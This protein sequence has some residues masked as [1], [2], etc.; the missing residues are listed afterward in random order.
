MTDHS[1]QALLPSPSRSLGCN[2]VQGATIFDSISLNYKRFTQEFS[3]Y[4]CNISL[5]SSFKVG[6]GAF[7][8]VTLVSSLKVWVHLQEQDHVLCVVNVL[9][10]NIAR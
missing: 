4:L 1:I 2:Y 9:K 7:A 10:I 5:L 8:S 6:M 3:G